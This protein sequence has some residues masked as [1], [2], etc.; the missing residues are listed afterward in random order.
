VKDREVDEALARATRHSRSADPAV[1]DRITAAIHSSLQPVR[2]LRGRRALTGTLILICTAV[3]FAGAA[4]LGFFGVQAL[5]PVQRMVILPVLAALAW[6][7]ASELVSHWIPGSR[8]HLT[9]QAL[10]ALATG[11]VVSVFGLLFHDYQAQHF[12]SAGI[13]C[14]CAGVLQAIPVAGLAAWLLRRGFAVDLISAGAIAGTLGGI[15]GVAMLELHCP[16][17]EAPHVLVWH[18]AVV[19]VS[20]TVGAL[21]GWSIQ[22]WKSRARLAS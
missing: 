18:S 7:T 16:N 3:S 14:L 15:S 8:H 22:A 21:V 5:G 4:R 2:P 12:I 6:L 11:I 17:L 19:P 13:V 9:P 10:V 1:L 20:A